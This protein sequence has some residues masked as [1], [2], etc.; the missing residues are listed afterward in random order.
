M[1]SNKE[2]YNSDLLLNIQ[3]ISL[4]LHIALRTGIRHDIVEA[5]RDGCN[6]FYNWSIYFSS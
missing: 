6:A 5:A 1:K 2:K 3:I 4:T